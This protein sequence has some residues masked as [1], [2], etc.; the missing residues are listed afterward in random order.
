[1]ERQEEYAAAAMPILNGAVA[2]GSAQFND[3][4]AVMADTRG[5]AAGGGRTSSA[6][7][8]AGALK[9]SAETAADV[10]GRTETMMVIVG[11][12]VVGLGITMSFT[13]TRS[14]SRPRAGGGRGRGRGWPTGI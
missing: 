10:A 14:I 7:T 4:V 13:L 6:R 9:R 12:L 11:V 3:A 5:C 2:V 1:M 8:S